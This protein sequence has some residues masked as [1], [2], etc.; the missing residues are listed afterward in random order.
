MGTGP[1]LATKPFVITRAVA[2]ENTRCPCAE[3]FCREG[4]SSV[5]A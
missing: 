3:A 2:Q 4:G 1:F 5:A